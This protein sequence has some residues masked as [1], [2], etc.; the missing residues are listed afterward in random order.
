M[1]G[2]VVRSAGPNTAWVDGRPVLRA[3]DSDEG[4]RVDTRD[5]GADGTPVTL[6]Q[7]GQAV[8][9]KPGQ[10][11]LPEQGQV[12]EQRTGTAPAPRR[13]EAPARP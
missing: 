8:R 2:L 7:G 4:M 13:P 1:N 10:T 3:E 9:L 11:Y 12:S 6:L 5:A